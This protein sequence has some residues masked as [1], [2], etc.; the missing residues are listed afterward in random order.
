MWK[1]RK[2]IL[3][4]LSGCLIAGSLFAGGASRAEAA[5]QQLQPIDLGSPIQTVQTVDV[6]FGK[7]EGANVIYTTVSGSAS[8]GAPAIFNVIDIDNQQ[9]L[10][11]FPLPGTSSSW[12][13]VVTPDGRVF[14]G[15]S[16]KMFMY[17]P[18]TGTI[19]DLG[20]PI[21]GTESIWALTSDENG[22][23]YGGIYSKSIGGRVFRID[24]NT[25]EI[26]DLLGGRVDDGT[27][28]GDDGKPEDYVRSI[29][30]YQG[31]VY[32]GTGSINGRVWKI[33]PATGEK[34]QLQLPEPASRPEYGGK[35]NAMGTTYGMTVVD[36]YLF[37]FFNGPFAMLVYD[38]DKEEWKDTIITNVRGLLAVTPEHNGKV[39]TSKKDG[40]LYEIDVETLTEKKSIPF[41]NSI[42]SS[43][44]LKVAN[45]PDFPDTA[46][47]TISYDGKVL[48]LDPDSGKKGVIRTLAEGQANNLQSLETGPDGKLYI[49]SYM[50]TIGAQYD[51]ATDTF[52][53]FP[54][55]QAE[56]MGAL[57]DTMYFG[58]YPKADIAAWDTTQ[59]LSSTTGPKSVFYIPDEQD[60]P[61][62]VT[63][64]GG[65]LFVGTIPLYGQHGGSL[66]IY[67]PE[68]SRQA[69]QP[70]VESY[71]HAVENQSIAGLAYKDGKIYGSTTINGGLGDDPIASRAK[72]FVWDVEGKQK[73]TE[74]D[75]KLDGLN[76]VP[77]I[78]G[79]TVGPEDG[80]IWGA[81]NGVLFALDPDTLEIVKHK[82]IYPEIDNY[83]MWRPVYIRWGQD[84]FLY[85]NI[86]GRLTVVDPHTLMHKRLGIDSPMIALDSE[87]N[88]YFVQATRLKKLP[89]IETVTGLTL[90]VPE[91]LAVGEKHSLGV[92]A[93]LFGASADVTEHARLTASPDGIVAI[94]NGQ[95]QALR[96]GT[97]EI[98]ASYGDK[99]V[100]R[101]VL[102]QNSVKELVSIEIASPERALIVGE[103]YQLHVTAVYADG[104]RE[105]VTELASYTVKKG[106]G[107]VELTPEG[108]IRTVKP[109][110]GH[111]TVKYESE[112]AQFKVQVRP[113]Q[114]QNGNKR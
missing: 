50:G 17:S 20:V 64:G 71:R 31:H 85:T 79:L 38:L 112:S 109:G 70:V 86:A 16:A 106:P 66:T 105:D 3:A 75:L 89:K 5:E 52:V 69:G 9:L 30:Y 101:T 22:N 58:L 96:P 28:P 56:G 26:T 95:I 108:L 83:G 94:E 35:Y 23:V 55:G 24:A 92:T 13:H 6:A 61:F 15:A 51:P 60:R 76:R 19:T 37:A 53:H 1:P 59:P 73:L 62:I 107:S 77:M 84:G 45:Q 104:T 21:K 98:T 113:A 43:A 25:L 57:G 91:Q 82:N 110:T 47:V 14:I 11:S 90:T 114:S 4:M 32:A 102:V 48:L 97:A 27:T 99:S 41:D 81:A 100:T 63:S 12:S 39:Y 74:F 78:S 44:W 54:L 42:R 80:L 46:M 103:E 67:D 111:I 29:A 18:A 68:A 34:T 65:K 2:T 88:L 72:L 93:D 36:H 40:H 7:E 8:G 87:D 49:S 10:R 33:N